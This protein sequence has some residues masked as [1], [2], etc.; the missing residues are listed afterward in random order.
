MWFSKGD[1]FMIVEI[2]KVKYKIDFPESFRISANSIEK[3]EKVISN[4]L[5]SI[6]QSNDLRKIVIES[7]LIIDFFVRLLLEQCFELASFTCDTLDPKYDLLPESF[8]KCIELLRTILREHRKLPIKQKEGEEIRASAGIWLSMERENPD[9]YKV[10][11]D[12]VEKYNKEKYGSNEEYAI[13]Y[14]QSIN[15]YYRHEYVKQCEFID[16]DWFDNV[17]KINK[18]R[19]KAAHMY[20]VNDIYKVFGKSGENAF[21]Q[22]K[23]FCLNIIS[24]TC[25]ISICDDQTILAD[26][27][28]Q[29]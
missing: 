13:I 11:N 28:S 15:Q 18:A 26:F 21:E 10:L 29:N 27:S 25:Y 4:C 22:S 14:L 7:W 9:L 16:D 24:K 17:M 23:T 19:N 2:N 6:S 20:D 1:I 8:K 12:F 3:L 5:M